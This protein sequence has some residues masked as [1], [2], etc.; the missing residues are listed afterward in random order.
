[1]PL[2]R[3]EFIQ[4]SA[5]SY[6]LSFAA[7]QGTQTPPAYV[8][9]EPDKKSWMIGNGLVE[10]QVQFD[11]QIGLFTP[12]WRHKLT[13]TDFIKQVP[14]SNS[15]GAEFSFQADGDRLAGSEGAFDLIG[16]ET[17]DLPPRGKVLEIK[18][19]ARTKP[20]EV[21]AFYGVYE[22]HPAVRKWIAI[23]NRSTKSFTLS[24]LSFEAVPVL[25]GNPS[26][27]QVSAFYGVQPREICFTGRAEDAAIVQR[28]SLTGEGYIVMNE[29][30][31]YMKR[32]EI[33]GWGLG[34]E[35]MYDTD[36]FPFERSVAPGETF[37]SAKSSVAFFAEQ[38]GFADPRWVMPSYTSQV[39]MRKGADFKPPW[40]YNAYSP[41]HE[42]INQDIVR[43]LIPVAGR[44]GFDIFTIDAGWEKVRGENEISPERFA[45]EL[46]SI[47]R[48]V[49][50]QGMRL[51]LWVPM[52][53]VSPETQAYREHPEWVCKDSHGQPKTSLTDQGQTPVMCLASPYRDVA[54]RQISDLISRY[55]LAYVKIDQTTVFNVYGEAPGCYAEGHYHHNWAES[56]EGIYEGMQYVT[57]Q[58]YRRHPD[59]L[60]DLTFELW[61]QKHIIDYG[62]IEAGDLD[63][64]SNV[65]DWTPESAGPRQIRTLLYHR[66]LAIP[67]ETMLIGNFRANVLPIEERFATTIGSGPLLLGD[68]RLLTPQQ[69]DWYGER[70][71]WFKNFRKEVAINEGFFPLGA[72]FQP[73]AASPD[74]FM[75]LN[76]EGEG[77][78][79]IFRNE[80][81]EDKLKVEMP[82]FPDGTFHIRSKITGVPLG[83]FSGAQMRQGIQFQVPGGHK[84]E[85]LEV[86]K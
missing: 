82:V 32:T 44:M 21:S 28:N 52:A 10:R 62:L 80:S 55:N 56:L 74:G 60:L 64:L 43:G 33:S 4:A 6:F 65:A 58:I 86:R 35:V 70:I 20:L 73:S 81:K 8:K 30:P 57:E 24:H 42:H 46:D 68:L 53:L 49:E 26:E 14:A 7:N 83:T 69:Q 37:T 12:A 75:R 5:A 16:A 25:A 63:W 45:G 85:V 84:V 51:A 71:R 18:L 77:L 50:R 36:I 38:Q 66:S 19:K 59:V 48:E 15:R 13:G 54:A 76:R 41:F 34:I 22:G 1:M 23:T 79:V 17:H 39:L 61:G 9:A 2:N 67:V 3:R 78:I 29:A 72:W 40:I 11:T 27:I 31:G 47:Q